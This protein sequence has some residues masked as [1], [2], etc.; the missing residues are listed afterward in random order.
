MRS[1][2]P[3]VFLVAR[4]SIDYAELAAYLREVGGTGWLERLGQ[5]RGEPR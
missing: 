3:E 5:R 4:P 1:V 2:Q